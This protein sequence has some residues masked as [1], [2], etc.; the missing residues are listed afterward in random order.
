MISAD[1]ML[2]VLL[3]RAIPRE[4]LEAEIARLFRVARAEIQDLDA[5]ADSVFERPTLV[6]EYVARDRGYRTQLTIHPARE[7]LLA[8]TPADETALAR[9]LASVFHTNALIA[10][11]NCPEQPGPF[12][13]LQVQPDGQ[14]FLV[15]EKPDEEDEGVAINDR[16]PAA[17]WDPVTNRRR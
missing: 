13:W 3:E 11:R 15:V 1:S 16:V 17:P 8:G 10:P 2:Q 9:S 5:A 7:L 6:T 4:D 14:W 12:D